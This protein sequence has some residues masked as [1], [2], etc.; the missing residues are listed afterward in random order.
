MNNKKN[1]NTS[2]N[3]DIKN[4]LEQD[5][6]TK[7][8]TQFIKKKEKKENKINILSDQI[9][10]LKNDIDNHNAVLDLNN[11]NILQEVNKK[12]DEFEKQ[13][14]RNIWKNLNIQLVWI[15]TV[16]IGLSLGLCYY[17]IKRSSDYT[18]LLIKKEISASN[19]ILEQKISRNYSELLNIKKQSEEEKPPLEENENSNNKKQNK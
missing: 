3:S 16:I 13:L 2:D 17:L 12:N 15:I 14:Y 8:F 9:Q 18:F 7:N 19:K 10:S 5:F 11:K 1:E 6:L 4:I